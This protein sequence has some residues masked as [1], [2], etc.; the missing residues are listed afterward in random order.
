MAMKPKEVK[1]GCNLAESSEGHS[2]KS[3]FANDDDDEVSQLFKY[4]FQSIQ[5]PGLVFS[6]VIIFHR[7]YDSLDE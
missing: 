7:L 3:C 2:S 6:L 5:G 1:T 4:L